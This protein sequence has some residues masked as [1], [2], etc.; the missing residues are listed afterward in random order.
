[1]TPDCMR[2]IKRG[3]AIAAHVGIHG[4]TVR[5]GRAQFEMGGI[6]AVA[7]REGFR[8]KGLATVCLEDAL[9]V[10]R[11][12][13]MQLS[14]LFGISNFYT[15][16]GFIGCYPNHALKLD[17]RFFEHFKNRFAVGN[18]KSSDL[19]G[20][21][22]LYEAASEKT[23]GAVVRDR[24]GFAFSI[25]DREL[26]AKKPKD[27]GRLQV[28]R[29]KGK[30]GKVRAYVVYDGRLAEAMVAP[31][32]EAACESVL[33]W[34]RQK[35]V[36]ALEKELHIERLAP[37]HP[38]WR[39]ALRLPHRIERRFNWTGDGMGQILDVDEFL[40]RMQPEFERR[41][42]GAGIVAECHLHLNV[43]GKDHSMV[44][45][46]SHLIT[47]A[48][49]NVMAASVICSRQALLQM[50]LGTFGIE[51]LPEVAHSGTKSLVR[52]L[53]PPAGPTMYT[54]DRF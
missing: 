53:F 24:K 1:V 26:A 45:C 11:D 20:M 29:E 25:E 18:Y 48:G 16:V 28:F 17:V 14:F 5:I 8:K 27:E 32:D 7:V 2:I 9:Q 36:E 33:A 23:P 22:K 43:D 13:G 38:L 15:K 50:C 52:A 21:L 12:K 39:Y 41:V 46:R 4:K 49:A 34:L 37:A 30:G 6:G 31:G 35:R 44:L 54:L 19:N 3:G 10:M 47:N 42:D 51:E 40:R